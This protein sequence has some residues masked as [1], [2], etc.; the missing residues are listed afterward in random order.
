MSAGLTSQLPLNGDE[1]V[2]GIQFEQDTNTI[3]DPAFRY[4]VSPDTSRPCAYRCC[5]ANV[6]TEQDTTGAPIAVLISQSLADRK[7]AG[8][9]PIGRHVRVGPDAGHADRPWATIVGV[10]G[11]VR[12]QSLAI[13]DEDAFYIAT[14]QWAWGDPVQ[15]VVVRTHG[16]PAGLAPSVQRAIW[17]VDKDCPISRVDS[18]SSVLAGTAVERRFVLILFEAFGVVALALA[19]V[20]ICGILAGSVTER[21]REAWRARG[22]GGNAR[23]YS[24]ACP[25]AGHEHDLRMSLAAGLCAALAAAR[26]L[27]AMLFG[28]T[29]LDG[30]TY[31]GV[32][33]LLFAVSAI[34]FIPARR[35]A[36]Y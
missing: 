24:R 6:L 23:R 1:D 33:A 25:A 28:V 34:A 12:Q 16:D 14:G 32:A 22:A 20:G 31:F 26:A 13:A 29:W 3:A 17:S 18:M 10:V 5:W 35:A 21:T 30:F 27:D 2:Y 19:A 7:F 36:S 8:R 11:N 4:S 9:N 15:S